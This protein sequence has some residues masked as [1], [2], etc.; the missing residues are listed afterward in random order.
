MHNIILKNIISGGQTGADRAGLDAAIILNIPTGGYCPK[1]YLTENGKDVSLK[2]YKLKELKSL[3]YEDRT[4]KNVLSS[5]GTVIFSKTDNKNICGEGSK[6][7]YEIA[8][9]NKKPVIINPTKKK[10]LNWLINNN[11]EILNVAGNR[12]SQFPGIYNKTKIF[13]INALTDNE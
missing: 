4:I 2:K 11:I 3:K 12:E 8:I 7:T 13:L 10:F 5:N 1:G 9:I 6:L